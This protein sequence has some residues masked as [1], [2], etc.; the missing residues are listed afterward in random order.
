MKK[1]I[2]LS[3]L[4]VAFV[5]AFA[6][7]K[8]TLQDVADGTYRPQNIYGIKPMLRNI[9]PPKHLWHQADAGR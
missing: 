7:Q 1:L 3:C 5:C 8:V 2:T 9:P 6:Q 4:L